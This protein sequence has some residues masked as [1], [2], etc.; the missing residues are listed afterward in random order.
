MLN[1]EKKKVWL[2]CIIWVKCTQDLYWDP[3]CS[4]TFTCFINKMVKWR[5][6]PVTSSHRNPTTKANRRWHL[7]P[8]N[9]CFSLHANNT[10]LTSHIHFNSSRDKEHINTVIGAMPA[11]LDIR[12]AVLV[13]LTEKYPSEGRDLIGLFWTTP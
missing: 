2:P 8:L 6:I 9:P 12:T 3:A 11:T 5:R 4:V 1:L 13:P 10:L 7:L